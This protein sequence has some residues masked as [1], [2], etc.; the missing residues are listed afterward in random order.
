MEAFKPNILLGLS[1]QPNIFDESVCR[2]M[3]DI[4][5]RPIIMPMSNPT[6]KSEAAPADIYRWTDGRAVV[7]TGSSREKVFSS[8][9]PSLPPSLSL[10]LPPLPCS[11]PPLFSFVPHSMDQRMRCEGYTIT[12]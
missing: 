12:A 3:A 10:S 11:H 1:T 4:N 2:T 9:P 8:L 6:S 5:K 7:A